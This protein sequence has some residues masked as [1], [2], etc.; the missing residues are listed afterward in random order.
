MGLKYVELAGT[1]GLSTAEFDDEIR[2]ADL[3]VS[4]SHVGIDSLRDNLRQVIKDNQI[5]GNRYVI[6][7]WVAEQYRQDWPATA[8]IL[9]EIGAKLAEY[10][11]VF[12]YHNHDFEMTGDDG[13]TGLDALFAASDPDSVKAQLDLGWIAASG[14]DP[15]KYIRRYS[16][17]L[18]LVHLK[19]YS[20][21]PEYHDSEPGW[22][23][24]DWANIIPACHEA[25]VDFGA[26]EMDEPLGDPLL[27][28]KRCAEYF[29]AKGLD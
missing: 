24:L 8:E 19:D 4:G 16:S 22:G 23:T 28:V 18:P 21:D 7:P 27:S 14:K 29:Q 3:L 17:R 5:F 13:E 2:K 12:A 26:I 25:G 6:L 10:D 15:I 20:G 1:Y 11:L 9:N